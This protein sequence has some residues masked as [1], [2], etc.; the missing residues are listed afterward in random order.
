MRTSEG[1]FERKSS[2]HVNF[3]SVGLVTERSALHQRDSN[4]NS[5]RNKVDDDD[6][7]VPTFVNAEDAL[8]RNKDA[9]SNKRR[10]TMLHANSARN[11][12]PP[13]FN[14]SVQLPS[15]RD[16]PLEK[17]STTD[18]K[19][20]RHERKC[21]EENVNDAV[22]MEIWAEKNLSHPDAGDK[23]VESSRFIKSTSDLEH[24]G[25]HGI[26]AESCGHGA[27][28]GSIA[29]SESQ[30]KALRYRRY[31]NVDDICNGTSD[32]KKIRSLGQNDMDKKDKMSDVVTVDSV[33]GLEI[34]PDDVVGVIGPKQFWKARRA[35]VK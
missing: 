18:A 11:D 21:N 35:I 32:D 26:F 33:T 1:E 23:P 3:R 16:M 28:E 22:V 14:S 19:S 10:L 31:M 6:F 20:G 17:T 27:L 13:S 8:Y 15:S 5:C 12:C 4:I 34:S 25:S 24:A 9:T 2:R 7:M 29:R 30:S